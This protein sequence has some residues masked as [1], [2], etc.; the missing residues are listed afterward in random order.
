MSTK[1]KPKTAQPATLGAVLEAV[2][3]LTARD[4]AQI[5]ELVSD[6]RIAELFP[7]RPAAPKKPVAD[8][9]DEEALT[10]ASARPLT[11][12][13]RARVIQASMPRSASSS[14]T[15]EAIG[16]EGALHDLVKAFRSLEKGRKR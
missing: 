8:F 3:A 14:A 2:A 1:K 12:R 11:A 13:Q 9:V 10:E 16:D 5:Q 6:G 4:E 7:F 15:F